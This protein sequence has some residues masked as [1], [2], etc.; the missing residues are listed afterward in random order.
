MEN[1]DNQYAK[2]FNAGYLLSQ[3]EPQLLNQ[4]LKGT[5]DDSQYLQGLKMGKKQYQ[6]EKTLSQQKPRQKEKRKER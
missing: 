1:Q 3:H 4:L 5:N 6:I 2:G